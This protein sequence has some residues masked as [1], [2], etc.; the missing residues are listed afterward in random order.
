MDDLQRFLTKNDDYLDIAKNA[1]EYVANNKTPEHAFVEDTQHDA[2]FTYKDIGANPQRLYQMEMEGIFERVFDTNSTTAYSIVDRESLAEA[3]SGVEGRMEEG[4][5]TAMHEFPED[6]EELEGVFDDVVGYEDVK[7]LMKR[8]M[9]T[10]DITNI[11][12]VGPPGSA[13]TV[14]LMAIQKEMPD[15]KFVT[16]KPT[17]GPG[18]LDTMFKETPKFMLIDEMDDMDPEV[19]EVLSQYTETGIVDETKMGKNRTLKTNTKTFGSANTTESIVPQIE[20][21]FLTLYFEPYTKEEF[22]EVCTHILPRNEG[23][24]AEESEKIAEEIWRVY[25]E[26]LVRKAIQVA[27]LSRG[28]PEKV[29]DVIDEYSPSDLLTL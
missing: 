26:G 24:D 7:W 21:R 1:L 14:F 10:D 25:E 20:D 29:I 27:R 13:K 23:K 3:V 22:I 2:F 18:V 19:Q 16:G 9:T 15:A 8:A 5:M 4:M 17:S 11:L 6:E 12:L 28:D